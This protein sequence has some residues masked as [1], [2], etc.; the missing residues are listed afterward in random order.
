MEEN[1]EVKLPNLSSKNN[2]TDNQPL[3]KNRLINPINFRIFDYIKKRDILNIN[4]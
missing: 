3:R 1:G 2:L 4:Q